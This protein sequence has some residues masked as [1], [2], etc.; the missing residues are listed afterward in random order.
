VI[1]SLPRIS[2]KVSLIFNLF[3]AS[4]KYLGI[5]CLLSNALPTIGFS[6]SISSLIPK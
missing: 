5:L 3:K 1:N 6:G 4:G 2:D